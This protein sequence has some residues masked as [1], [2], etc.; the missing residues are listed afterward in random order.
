MTFDIR[1]ERIPAS[2]FPRR[3]LVEISHAEA[4]LTIDGIVLVANR[5]AR[6]SRELFCVAGEPP[7]QRM[8]VEKE[9]HQPLLAPRIEFGRR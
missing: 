2:S 9:L 8:G 4:A 5:R 6:A 3:C 1:P 7:Q